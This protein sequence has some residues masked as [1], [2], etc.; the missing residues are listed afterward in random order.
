MPP[1]T[2]HNGQDL[3]NQTSHGYLVSEPATICIIFIMYSY[4]V[5]L[6]NQTNQLK[7]TSNV[8]SNL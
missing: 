1:D 3:P 5:D 2:S 6:E 8:T 4:F 7:I